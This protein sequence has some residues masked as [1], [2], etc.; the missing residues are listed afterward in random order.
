[1]AS[2]RI[3]REHSPALFAAYQAFLAST[4]DNSGPA[5]RAQMRPP[6]LLNGL[7]QRA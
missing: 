2:H 6:S 1:M 3:K 5:K 4:I 7:H